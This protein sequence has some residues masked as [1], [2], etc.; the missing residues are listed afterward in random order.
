MIIRKS[1]TTHIPADTLTV[2]TKVTPAPQAEAVAESAAEV[3]EQAAP[4]TIVE[5]TTAVVEQVVPEAVVEVTEKAA[6]ETAVKAVEKVTTEA[7]K[8]VEKAATEATKVV[9]K[10]ATEV[11]KVAE[12]ATSKVTPE[13][14]EAV[15]KQTS[16]VVENAPK[17]VTEDIT[18]VAEEVVD[19]AEE[20]VEEVSMVATDAT[21]ALM[22]IA[23]EASHLQETTL[24]GIFGGNAQLVE[25]VM[26]EIVERGELTSNWFVGIFIVAIFVYYLFILFAYGSHIGLMCKVIV[27]N[28]IGIR[29]AD[30]L[31]YLFMR[32]E[33]NAVALGITAWSMIFVKWIEM[34]GAIATNHWWLLGIVAIAAIMGALQRF[35]TIGIF[36]LVRRR[37]VC[38]GINI[39]ADTTMALAAIVV[40]PLA[41]LLTLNT[42]ATTISLSWACVAVGALALTIFCIKS[43][44]LF[45]G[46]KISILLWF[47]YL[48]TVILI[49]IGVVATIALRGGA[50]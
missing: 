5:T 27:S 49:P 31:S 46:Q 12:K 42:G 18:D 8:V 14:T 17:E 34:S 47:L 21:D 9:E 22:E 37:E 4:E 1:L 25:Q 29:V 40:T 6:A 20:M 33:R 48:C 44:I 30:E 24:D 11:T 35:V 7:T 28:N 15:T 3:V 41:L 50:I 45:I 19:V 32:A 43:L 26:P 2:A 38:E 10:A 16:K 13:V 23:E 36:S 39:L